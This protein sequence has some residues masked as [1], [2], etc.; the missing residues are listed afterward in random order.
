MGGLLRFW[1]KWQKAV[2]LSSWES[3]LYAAV[4]TGVEVFGFQSGL[5]DFGNNTRVMI[6]CD[7]QGVVDHTARQ[8]PLMTKKRTRDIFVC[9]QRGMKAG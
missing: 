4:S 6:A 7:N 5:R 3:E 2:S 9:K 1:S 8:G